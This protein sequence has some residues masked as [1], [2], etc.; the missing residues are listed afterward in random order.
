MNTMQSAETFNRPANL[1]DLR[2][3]GW[4]SRS[5]KQELRD[6][7]MRMLAADEELFPASW[8]RRHGYSRYQH[9][10]SLGARYSVLGRK[11]ASQESLNAR[12]GA[13]FRPE[14]P[15]LD[16]PACRFTKTLTNRSQRWASDSWRNTPKKRCRSLGGRERN[17]TRND[18]VQVLS[19]LISSVK[20][21]RRN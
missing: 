17:A 21:I 4:R 19:S 20:L 5:V 13:I 14:V 3:S 10:H 11:G 6:N 16:V 8:L 2:E 12:L 1:A 9:R 18:S 15:Y 7:F